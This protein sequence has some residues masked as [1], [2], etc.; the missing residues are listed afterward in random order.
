M[1]VFVECCG[2]RSR[3]DIIRSYVR[4]V[5]R[6][7]RRILAS[8]YLTVSRGVGYEVRVA[9]MFGIVRSPHLL[10]FALE[11]DGCY[12]WNS[13]LSFGTWNSVMTV[14]QARSKWS[15]QYPTTVATVETCSFQRACCIPWEV[16]AVFDHVLCCLV[17]LPRPREM[18][19]GWFSS[20][21]CS[22]PLSCTRRVLKTAAAYVGAL[23]A[24]LQYRRPGSPSQ[25][26]DVYRVQGRCPV[27][28]GRSR[29]RV[30]SKP[31]G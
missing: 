14:S 29:L 9:V 2:S 15:S 1:V 20:R 5:I 30:E 8:W 12:R 13:D 25:H 6:C 7:C 27:G 24:A 19:A 26:E 11:P 22:A 17:S 23:W 4:G 21:C 18:V 3:K 31:R 16:S 28:I 10:V